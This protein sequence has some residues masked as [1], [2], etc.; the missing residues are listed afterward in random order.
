MIFA[1]DN[2]AGT[3]IMAAI[4]ANAAKRIPEMLQ[5]AKDRAQGQQ[6]LDLGIELV[7]SAETYQYEPPWEPRS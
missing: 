1:T 6:T 4:Y 7:S 2:D 3:R 5:E